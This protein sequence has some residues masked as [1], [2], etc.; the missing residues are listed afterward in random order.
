MGLGLGWLWPGERGAAEERP[1]LVTE[2]P[3]WMGRKVL[4]GALTT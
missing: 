4:G 1:G 2:A 3:L